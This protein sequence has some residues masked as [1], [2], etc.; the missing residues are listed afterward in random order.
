MQ[1]FNLVADWL[2][3]VVAC[4]IAF[5]VA[6]V[7]GVV[8]GVPSSD[9]VEVEVSKPVPAV[10]VKAE[11]FPNLNMRLRYPSA[12][13]SF[14]A[15]FLPDFRGAF[16]AKSGR[17]PSF[18]LSGEACHVSFDVLINHHF[19]SFSK[20]KLEEVMKNEDSEEWLKLAEVSPELESKIERALLPIM[21]RRMANKTLYE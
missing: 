2:F 6:F 7:L 18:G 8:Y 11:E 13:E 5:S 9:T 15:G 4:A 21:V 17:W 20:D 14:Q 1:D 12:Y 3:K 19:G 16:H 10:V